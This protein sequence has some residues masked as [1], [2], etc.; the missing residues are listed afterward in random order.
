MERLRVGAQALNQLPLAW[1]HNLENV[2]NSIQ[3]AISKKCQFR[4]GVEY[5]LCGVFCGVHFHDKNFNQKVWDSIEAILRSDTSQNIV[6]EVGTALKVNHLIYNCL[7]GI[8]KN[9][10]LYIHPSSKIRTRSDHPSNM[11]ISEHQ[12]KSKKENVELP[13]SISELINQKDVP[14][15][16]Y[17]LEI[18][19]MSVFSVFEGELDTETA[20]KI[21]K[22]SPD[23]VSVSHSRVFEK[24]SSAR[25][26]QRI[27]KNFPLKNVIVNTISGSES[28]K[29][30]FEGG[31]LAFKQEN[32]HQVLEHLSLT[33]CLHGSAEFLSCGNSKK[34][35]PA[36]FYK[37]KVEIALDAECQEE[38][39]LYEED[40]E[41]K[42]MLGAMSPFFSTFF[43]TQNSVFFCLF[44]VE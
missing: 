20:K 25:F 23:L 35:S 40:K 4:A 42:Q 18:N 13:A 6:I 37:I 9:K 38:A 39:S 28:P 5:E 36:G 10:L 16:N 2:L 21:L 44:Q 43:R 22:F 31:S 8:Y 17:F 11:F 1:E 15:G 19:K 26:I 30:I 3:Q 24:G 27:K 29:T 34:N 32:V 33:P 7:I 14:I 41:E 12:I